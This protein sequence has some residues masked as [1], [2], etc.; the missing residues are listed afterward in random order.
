MWIRI[1]CRHCLP[2]FLKIREK[3]I[4]YLKS[5]SPKSALEPNPKGVVWLFLF[6]E[7]RGWREWVEFENE[8]IRAEKI[9][10]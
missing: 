4:Q 7:G 1:N 6:L 8:E 10:R 9:Y 3:V 2:S 5:K